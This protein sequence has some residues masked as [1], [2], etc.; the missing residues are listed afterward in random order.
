MVYLTS[1]TQKKEVLLQEHTFDL[2]S[3]S[4]SPPQ[5]FFLHPE[6]AALRVINKIRRIILL[7]LRSSSI[8]RLTRSALS[9]F[10][11]VRPGIV[12]AGFSAN[13]GSATDT[14]RGLLP[15]TIFLCELQV[16][17]RID[18]TFS[19]CHELVRSHDSTLM[20]PLLWPRLLMAKQ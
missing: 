6:S 17:E 4:I 18:G 10:G 11:K 16:W 15:S 5:V 3:L 1:L 2:P 19:C 7:T 14:E 13:V 12:I 9:S 8:I 20:W